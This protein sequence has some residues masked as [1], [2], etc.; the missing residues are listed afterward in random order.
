MQNKLRKGSKDSFS[1]GFSFWAVVIKYG[2]HG[3]SMYSVRQREQIPVGM[4]LISPRYAS[5]LGCRAEPN[6]GMELYT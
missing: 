1:P 5:S 3:Y 6:N 2:L 4:A